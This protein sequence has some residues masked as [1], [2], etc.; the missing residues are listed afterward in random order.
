LAEPQGITSI[1]ALGNTIVIG[2]YGG[3]YLS[4]NLGLAWTVANFTTVGIRTVESDHSG[5][6]YAG[7]MGGGIFRSSDNGLTWQTANIGLAPVN[8]T[9][10]AIGE[11]GWMLAGTVF[12]GLYSSTDQG[13]S[14][15]SVP[16]FDGQTV[17]AVEY[18]A[19]GRIYVG[20]YNFLGI[21]T[22]S[23]TYQSDDDGA[24]WSSAGVG[25]NITT[26]YRT[27]DDHT[28]VISPS[29]IVIY[30]TADA[31]DTTRTWSFLWWRVPFFF[32]DPENYPRNTDAHAVTVSH[33]GDVYIGG[34]DRDTLY[35]LTL[36]DTTWTKK[37]LGTTGES[38]I[39]ALVRDASDQIF[40]GTV[41]HGLYSSSDHGL[42]WTP[43]ADGFTAA[44]VTSLVSSMG[45][46]LYAGTLGGEVY[47]KTTS[48]PDFPF[49]I[50]PLDDAAVP[51]KTVAFTWT[52]NSALTYKLQVAFDSLFSQVRY[53]AATIMGGADT[54][55]GIWGDTTYYWRVQATNKLGTGAWSKVFSFTFA[56]GVLDIDESD[57]IPTAYAL[58]QNF[59]NP[60]NPTTTM[61]FALPMASNITLRVFDLRGRVV[62]E[63]VSGHWK[64]GYHRVIWNGKTDNG[65][66]VPSGIYIAHLVTPDYT[67]SIKM[68]LLK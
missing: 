10:I 48:V 34:W 41:G 33:R 12:G 32:G 17:N 67:K 59:P 27:A 4:D 15:V 13:D 52:A 36:A 47:Y 56:V 24:T 44:T 45:A 7:T 68:V 19:D 5:I 61:K 1:V 37:T 6:V 60:F 2:T 28:F 51:S 21:N 39:V 58:H 64:S 62:R 16:F 25:G 9:D 42:T 8:V 18:G 38:A 53:E 40:A 49:L 11:S 57:Q 46:I 43:D 14:W 26:I 29:N 63:L 54:V 3:I 31:A 55:S 35:Q 50:S 20:L 23:G 65:R 66:D 22:L 30:R